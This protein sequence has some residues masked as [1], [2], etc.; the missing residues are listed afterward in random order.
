ML[1]SRPQGRPRMG[2]IDELR[3][4]YMKGSK[5]IKESFERLIEKGA[6]F[7]HV[8]VYFRTHYKR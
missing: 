6:E 1:G 2:M 8:K 4:I 3:E 5:K 7:F